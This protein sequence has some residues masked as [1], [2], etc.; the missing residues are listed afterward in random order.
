MFS[1]VIPLYNKELSIKNTIQSVLD[2]TF[3]EFEIIVVNDGSTDKSMQVVE[4]I[5]DA[6]IRIIDKPNGGVSSARNRG[7]KEAKNEWIA[8]LDG[9]DLWKENHLDTFYELISRYPE[10]KVFC[11]S[12]IRSNL[13][14]PAKEDSSTQVIE[15]YFDE[16]IKDHFFWTSVTVI[17]RKVFDKVG[18]FKEFLSRGEDLDLWA[19]IGMHYQFIKSNRITAIYVQDSTNKLTFTTVPLQKSIVGNISFIGL[20][21]SQKRYFKKLLINKIRSLIL[22]GDLKNVLRLL[23]RYNF[24]LF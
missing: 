2:Q 13:N 24:R 21:S 11:T 1:V 10:N 18:I 23:W 17:N 8:F 20:T 5:V 15:N 19:R 3:S 22:V 14:F 4:E 16:A 6:R 9:D 12:F 7:I